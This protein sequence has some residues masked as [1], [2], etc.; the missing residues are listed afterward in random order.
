MGISSRIYVGV[1]KLG[2]LFSF[3]SRSQ[4]L[5]P[6][7][8]FMLP[9]GDVLL[10]RPVCLFFSFLYF[11]FFF[12]LIYNHVLSCLVFDQCNAWFSKRFFFS[13]S[14]LLV[15]SDFLFWLLQ[16]FC[17]WWERDG[18]TDARKQMLLL[19]SGLWQWSCRF[20]CPVFQFRFPLETNKKS[21]KFIRAEL[22][23]SP[24]LLV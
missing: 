21:H 23:I 11:C 22:C 2:E 9:L 6:F 24:L 20:S 10:G 18:E 17:V 3:H 15:N 14:Y 4:L 8:A 1:C 12:T 19:F 7:H 16:S 5:V 13:F